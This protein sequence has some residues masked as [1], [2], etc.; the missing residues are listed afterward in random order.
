MRRL[1]RRWSCC[2]PRAGRPCGRAHEHFGEPG[3]RYC[4]LIAQ[5]WDQVV[6]DA[7][8]QLGLDRSKKIHRLGASRRPATI[9]RARDHPK[10]SA[11]RVVEPVPVEHHV[12]EYIGVTGYK[13]S[14][15][16]LTRRLR[17]K[18]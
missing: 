18:N 3:D 5:C 14:C 10:D 17:G 6:L 16:W 13:A 9:H 12:D 7:E 11:Y 8:A 2:A 15:D 4:K 1:R